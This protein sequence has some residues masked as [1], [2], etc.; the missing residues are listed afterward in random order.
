[1]RW[2]QSYAAWVLAPKL[3]F[4]GFLSPFEIPKHKHKYILR[5]HSR[6]SNASLPPSRKA[7]GTH[8]LCHMFIFAP[9]ITKVY[10]QKRSIGR[11]RMGALPSLWPPAF[12]LQ[13]LVTPTLLSTH[14]RILGAWKLH[15]PCDALVHQSL[16]KDRTLANLAKIRRR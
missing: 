6:I 9:P 4:T 11:G 1:M 3:S 14:R 13:T 15:G 16:S 8:V 10:R 7:Y 12:P 2:A 5:T